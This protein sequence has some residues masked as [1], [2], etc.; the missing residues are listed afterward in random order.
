MSGIY[1][2]IPF[3][4][5]A[6]N[7]CNFH[8]STTLKL[9][10][11]I[12]ASIC[13]EIEI[14]KDYLSNKH[15]DSIYFGGGTPSL[16][17]DNDLENIFKSLSENF[18]WD[19]SAEITLEANPDDITI[20]KIKLF[21]KWGINRL[22]IGIQS[23]Y[24]EDLHFMNRAHNAGEAHNCIQYSQDGGIDNLSIDLIYGSNS[25]SN[26]MW[27]SNLHKAIEFDVP[28]I[29]PYCLTVEDKT[30]LHH[31]IKEKKIQPLNINKASQQFEL[32]FN[33]LTTHGFDHYEI[34]N[35][36]KPNNYALHNTNYWKGKDYLGIGPSAHSFNG[37]SRSWNVSNNKKYLD[38]LDLNIIPSEVECLTQADKY[39]E[40][41]MTGLR[42]MWGIN[43]ENISKY[44][45]EF[46]TL[47]LK[48]VQIQI[49]N[50]YII[51]NA[52]HYI[53]STKGKFFADRIAS[54]LFWVD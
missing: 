20:E 19:S 41:V 10:D 9:K 22:S 38:S 39:N 2:H 37:S 53:L 43:M 29:S 3:C 40:Y 7:Y 36:A 54:E 31:Q 34:S 1:I 27:L 49:D 4:K 8:F 15:L 6:C 14:R 28:H 17:N 26:E 44:G 16:M 48:D 23:F 47:F 35:F 52:S 45:Y 11:Q 12:I 25:T 13:K 42:T 33:T 18:T 5:Q 46:K 50:G 30:T 21:K 32:L 51:E 24:D